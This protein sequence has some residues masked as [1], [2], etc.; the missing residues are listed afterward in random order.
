[1]QP[2]VRE[3][4]GYAG[5]S[6]AAAAAVTMD[7]PPSPSAQGTILRAWEDWWAERDGWLTRGV[8]TVLL[9][10]HVACFAMF[11]ALGGGG[12]YEDGRAF[13]WHH[14]GWPTPWFVY[15]LGKEPNVYFQ[16]TINFLASSMLIAAVGMLAWYAFWRIQLVR[17]ASHARL[18]R[19][20]G[21]PT[22]IF[23]LWALAGAAL[24]T[25]GAND[26]ER[27]YERMRTTK[28][29]AEAPQSGNSAAEAHPSG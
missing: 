29:Q 15:E 12:G 22:A 28:A 17:D 3:A 9:V 10:V 26:A 14:V 2:E 11:S 13:A 8:L 20:I 27:L 4:F 7:Q 24:A 23:I 25:L 1:M 16:R 18:W 6:Q 21:S 19:T 5:R